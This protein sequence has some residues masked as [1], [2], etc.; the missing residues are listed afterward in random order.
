MQRFQWVHGQRTVVMVGVKDVSGHLSGL[1]FNGSTVREPWL[2]PGHQHEGG[3]RHE[4]FNGSTVRE[5]W[6]WP[7]GMVFR[8]PQ[9]VSMGPRSEN[10]GYDATDR[11]A[12][13]PED[14]VSMGPRSENR[15]YAR[16]SAR[17]CWP[18]SQFQ[19][20]HGQRTVVMTADLR[21]VAEYAAFQW[22][23]G[24]R[25]V[26]MREAPAGAQPA[27][28]VSMG[29]RSENRGY[30]P[31]LETVRH[32]GTVS[33]GPR[34]ENRG[35]AGAASVSL[36]KLHPSFNGSTVREPWLWVAFGNSRVTES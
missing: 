21:A 6:L 5:P 8:P 28:R 11:I 31:D 26:V 10:R 9:L 29:P 13:K 12:H 36:G 3:D 19:W 30:A 7:N 18:A 4:G 17:T 1:R 25:T 27:L 23:H 16:P 24:Q 33:M 35:Y 14:A 34:S 32:D 15:G 22:V 2:C 20:V